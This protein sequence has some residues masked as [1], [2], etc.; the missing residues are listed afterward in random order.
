MSVEITGF[1]LGLFRPN[2]SQARHRYNVAWRGASL[3]MDPLHRLPF[4]H[5]R[6]S[7]IM[8]SLPVTC[9]PTSLPVT[10]PPT[11]L[12]VTSNM[13]SLQVKMTSSPG[14][15][16][17]E[18]FNLA[19]YRRTANCTSLQANWA[20]LTCTTMPAWIR[21]NVAWSVHADFTASLSFNSSN[22]FLNEHISVI[23]YLNN[24]FSTF[25]VFTG[26]R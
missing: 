4:P 21:Y 17:Y 18:Y 16:T 2:C 3:T 13:T 20:R 9:P 1:R 5:F 10:Y 26:K 8:T 11:S 22:F 7:S 25:N 24:F 6:S 19:F 12:P 14:G 23:A 15:L